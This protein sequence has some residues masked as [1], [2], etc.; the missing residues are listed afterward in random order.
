MA[1][2]LQNRCQVCNFIKKRK[3]WYTWT[4]L[5]RLLFL[6]KEYSSKVFQTLLAV[7]DFSKVVVAEVFCKKGVLENFA[8][9]RCFSWDLWDFQEHRFHRTPPVAADQLKTEAV[10]QRC[11]LRK[12][13]LEILLNS[14]KNTCARV[15]FLQH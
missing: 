11:S 7:P 3:K 12:V 5:L 8:N 6:G 13:C 1:D 14:Q 4:V 2:V 9:H 15:F 10:V